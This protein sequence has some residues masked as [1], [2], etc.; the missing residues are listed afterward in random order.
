MTRPV[1]IEVRSVS[2][3]FR[4][5]KGRRTMVE[6][7]WRLAT[8]DLGYT[9]REVLSDLTFDVYRG[10]CFGI[11]G[12]NG[13]GKS[14]LLRILA[15]VTRPT[16]GAVRF[17]GQVSSLLEL[18][19]GF[20]SELSG[21]ENIYLG[22]AL[23]GLTHEQIRAAEQEIIAF[24]ELGEFIDQPIF[25]YSSGMLVRLGFSVA[26]AVRPEIL[27]LDEVLAVGDESFRQKSFRAINE[28]RQSGKTVVLVSHD[29]HQVVA[30][31][32]RAMFLSRGRSVLIGDAESAVR[33][34]LN[35][36]QGGGGTEYV[37]RGALSVALDHGRTLV[38][39]RGKSVTKNCGIYASM[40]TAS[41]WLDALDGTWQTKRLDDA[42]L[43]STRVFDTL[44]MTLRW[45]V[46]VRSETEIEVELHAQ[47]EKPVTV[48]RHHASVLLDPAFVRWSTADACGEFPPIDV[49][50][51]DWVHLNSVPLHSDWI[52]ASADQALPEV[53]FA[54]TREAE[55]SSPTVLNTDFRQNCRVL[56]FLQPNP[57][58]AVWPPGP[59]LLFAGKL[60]LRP[61]AAPTPVPAT[62]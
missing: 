22:A 32:D 55:A 6:D 35:T 61:S 38:F 29:L 39:F 33:F 40:L 10:E 20:H 24:S 13:S 19:A 23:Y 15:G 49:A 37:E 9:H 31:C 45:T 60:E 58:A 2:K 16:S 48:E 18:G 25:T 56:Q 30:F 8:G 14:T 50:T 4:L 17:R 12:P 62:T 53:R 42:T 47:L 3:T 1:D 34:Y 57:L 26:L 11:V 43:E 28:V 5:R 36:T 46:R 44:A 59:R 41:G 52:G 27:V 21:R 54:V 7:L 51:H